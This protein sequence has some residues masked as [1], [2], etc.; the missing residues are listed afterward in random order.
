M[1]YLTPMYDHL[2]NIYSTRT[3]ALFISTQVDF[4]RVLVTITKRFLVIVGTK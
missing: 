3:V 1:I 2:V 4:D